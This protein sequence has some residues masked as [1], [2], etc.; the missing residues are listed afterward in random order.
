MPK[1]LTNRAALSA[2]ARRRQLTIA[3]YATVVF[4]YWVALY[5]YVPTLP[6]YVQGKSHHLALVGV[7]LAQYGLW[8]AIIRLPLGIAADWLGWHKPFILAGLAL[9]GLGT[10]TLGAAEGAGQLALGRAITGLA[11]GTWVPLVVCSTACFAPTRR[12]G[13]PRC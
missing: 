10:L 1:F 4:L 11:A 9:A 7:V 6:T 2:G 3:L 8:Q 5:I 13:Q 12:C